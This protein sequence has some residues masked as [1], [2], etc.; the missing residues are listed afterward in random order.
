MKGNTMFK[1]RSPRIIALVLIAIFAMTGCAR[2]QIKDDV[3]KTALE[4]SAF[5]LGYLGAQ[6][7]PIE[8]A[9]AEKVASAML[10]EE[11]PIQGVV[12]ALVKEIGVVIEDP[13][14]L[15]Q[16]EKLLSCLELQFEDGTLLVGEQSELVRIALG[17]FMAGIRAARIGGQDDL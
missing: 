4:V 3:A 1:P 8:F 9:T 14:L 17:E 15:Y 12:D 2:L 16:G 6:R 13:L 11:G 5:T 10:N 7:Y